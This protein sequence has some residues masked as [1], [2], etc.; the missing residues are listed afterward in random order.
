MARFDRIRIE[1]EEVRDWFEQVLRAWV[2]GTQQ[3]TR[4]QIVELDRQI[5]RMTDQQVKLLNLRLL[6]QIDA[7]TF[8]GKQTELRNQIETL[9]FR[10][11][12]P[13][14]AELEGRDC[15]QSIWTFA[16]ASPVVVYRNYRDKR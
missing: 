12:S 4:H 10:A 6:H 16:N 2:K 14:A 9:S 5:T 3:T 11:S 8:A 15:R 1:D 13:T 7:D